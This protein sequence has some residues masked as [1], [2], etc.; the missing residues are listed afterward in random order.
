MVRR[1]PASGP[2]RVRSRFRDKARAFDD[3]YADERPD[4]P[5]AVDERHLPQSGGSGVPL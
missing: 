1:M 2:E 3:L 4:P 5:L